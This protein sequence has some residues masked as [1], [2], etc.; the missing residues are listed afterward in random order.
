MLKLDEDVA[1]AVLIANLKGHKKKRLSLVEIAKAVRF[2]VDNSGYDSYK[3]LSREFKIS[4]SIISAFDKINDHPKEVINLIKL[5]KIGLDASTKL[6]TKKDLKKRAQMAKIVSGLTAFE[7]RQ[8]IDYSK[9]HPE[10][11]YQKCKEIVLK[12]APIKRHIHVV[13][14]PLEEK[15]FSDFEKKCKENHLVLEKGATLA[16]KDWLRR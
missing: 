7:T 8:V 5:E 4:S 13:V 15:I 11:S 14:V 2:L 12:S 6:L 9:K 1:K 3:E 10:L 16:I